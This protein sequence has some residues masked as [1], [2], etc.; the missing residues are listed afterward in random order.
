MT[1][2]YYTMQWKLTY[3]Y[4]LSQCVEDLFGHLDGLGEVVLAMYI[5]HILPWVVP[6]EV[7]DW[8]LQHGT[9]TYFWL[10]SLILLK[11]KYCDK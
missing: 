4:V 1:I 10:M 6:V 9:E 8:L 3:L 7:T 5:N 11:T 2:M